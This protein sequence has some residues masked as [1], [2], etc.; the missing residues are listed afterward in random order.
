M[1]RRSNFND[2][3][4]ESQRFDNFEERLKVTLGSELEPEYVSPETAGSEDLPEYIENF[5]LHKQF[6][7][8]NM[9]S[10]ATRGTGSVPSDDQRNSKRRRPISKGDQDDKT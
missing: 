5:P 2:E 8:T 9:T 4:D 7:Q 1:S 6:R 10:R 3:P